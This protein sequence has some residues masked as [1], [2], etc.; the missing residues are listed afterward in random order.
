M[1]DFEFW[2][3]TAAKNIG[4]V[5]LSCPI[6]LLGR[7]PLRSPA[8]PGGR[9]SLV[10]HSFLCSPPSPLFCLLPALLLLFSCSVCSPLVVPAPWLYLARFQAPQCLRPVLRPVGRLGRPLQIPLSGDSPIV[11]PCRPP[12]HQFPDGGAGR[13]VRL[14][15]GHRH[16]V[17][18]CETLCTFAA[19]LAPCFPLLPRGPTPSVCPSLVPCLTLISFFFLFS[20]APLVALFAAHARPACAPCS[21]PCY[22]C[23]AALCPLPRLFLLPSAVSLRVLP[24]F[25]RPPSLPL[26]RCHS[27][28]PYARS[29]PAPF[30]RPYPVPWRLTYP[31]VFPSVP[32]SLLFR[33]A[34]VHCV[35]GRGLLAD[36]TV[37]LLVD[38]LDTGRWDST[39]AMSLTLPAR[40]K[41]SPQ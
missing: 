19:L 31:C 3:K 38:G 22:P 5:F 10:S 28:V 26:P 2:E 17:F 16:G 30:C 7:G 13:P 18:L 27:C 40:V 8:M 41:S 11:L 20:G 24:V 25:L 4:A 9:P 39:T 32:V 6:A 21:S 29:T 14:N 35:G 12:L 33:D 37:A 1:H 15:A 36:L 34:M 23:L